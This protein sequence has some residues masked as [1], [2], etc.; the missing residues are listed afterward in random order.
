M[1]TSSER[2]RERRELRAARRGDRDGSGPTLDERAPARFPGATAK[3]GLLGEVLMTG[4]LVTL[5]A[6][7]V[8]T[9]PVALAAGI[10]HLR[11]FVRAEGSHLSAFWSDVRRGLAGGALLG[12]AVLVLTGLFALDIDLAAS[13]ALPGGPVIAVVGW[14][15]LA[16]LAIAVL[17]AAMPPVLMPRKATLSSLLP[18][19]L[20]LPL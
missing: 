8:V 18:L 13:G 15:G 16:A 20:P 7:P 11:R 17:T 1:T 9:L 2:A 10:R 14:A 12:L 5:V 3:F 6:V 4:L 19:S